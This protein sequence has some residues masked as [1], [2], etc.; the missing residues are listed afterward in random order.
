MMKR[1]ASIFLAGVLFAGGLV[2]SGMT[3]P[4]KVIGFLDFGGN[5]DPS[6]A[7]VML[8]A[9]SV[10]ALAYRVMAKRKAPI[11]APTFQIPTRR[12]I[13]VRLIL[14]AVLFGVGWG[15]AGYCPGPAVSSIVAGDPSTLTFFGSLLSTL[16]VYSLVTGR[17]SG[18]ANRATEDRELGTPHVVEMSRS[19]ESQS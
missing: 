17:V 4:S 10:H 5:W 1:L 2:I 16:V 11:L 14:G 13:D 8:G 9:I 6:L 3:Q 18:L 7:F 15:L 19:T 12:D